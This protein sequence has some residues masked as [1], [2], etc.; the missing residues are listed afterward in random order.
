MV[1]RV[2]PSAQAPPADPVTRALARSVPLQSSLVETVAALR[3]VLGQRSGVAATVANA[4]PAAMVASASAGPAMLTNALQHLGATLPQ[5]RNLGSAPQLRAAVDN[6]ATSLEKKLALA[7]AD[8]NVTRAPPT[9]DLR[10][11]LSRIATLLAS[12]TSAEQP[13]TTMPVGVARMM[14]VHG[15]APTEAP[16]TTPLPASH[17]APVDGQPG[18]AMLAAE[19]PVPRLRELV[20]QV[21]QRLYTHHLSNAQQGVGPHGS[22]VV[23][24]PVIHEQRLDLWHFEFSHEEQAPDRPEAEARTVVSVKLQL[25]EDYAVSA[26]L[27]ASGDLLNVRLGSDHADLHRMIEARVAELENSMR[28]RGLN[29]NAVAVGPVNLK[30]EPSSALSGLIR[31]NV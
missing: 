1:L 12:A 11:Q 22:F 13:A 7:G 19:T 25:A 14:S 2:L 28:E 15:S 5:V 3:A 4:A 10:A 6:A 8:K 17:R 31:E 27:R 20:E 29:L 30:R 21:V 26:E 23:E 9:T 18:L 24:F 16:G